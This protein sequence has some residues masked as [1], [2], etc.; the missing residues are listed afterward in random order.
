M[1]AHQ[2]LNIEHISVQQFRTFRHG[3]NSNKARKYFNKANTFSGTKTET[4]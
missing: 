3:W 1:Y 4:K 2:K